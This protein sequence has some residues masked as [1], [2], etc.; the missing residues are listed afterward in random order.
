MVCGKLEDWHGVK[1][2]VSGDPQKKPRWSNTGALWD[3]Q[4]AQAPLFCFAR[5]KGQDKGIWHYRD[6]RRYYAHGLESLG[7]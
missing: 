1:E 5:L 7:C 4:K 2:G 6:G 3:T